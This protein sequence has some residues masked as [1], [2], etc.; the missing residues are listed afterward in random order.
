M[1]ALVKAFIME[2]S[3]ATH[4]VLIGITLGLLSADQQEEL[5]VLS[6]VFLFHQVSLA[7]TLCLTLTPYVHR[8]DLTYSLYSP[9][10]Q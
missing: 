1:K 10:N 6:I 5:K 2:A 4:S 8:P 7:F 9:Y 3:I